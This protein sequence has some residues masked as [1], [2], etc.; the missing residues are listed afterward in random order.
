MGAR[1]FAA[2]GRALHHSEAVLLVNHAK[3]Q[4][5]EIHPFLN[6]GVGADDYVNIT[7]RDAL[8][9]FLLGALL[10]ASYYE[11]NADGVRKHRG[12]FANGLSIAGF[13][14]YSAQQ[15]TNRIEVLL[16]QNLCG[17]HEC[18][19]IA[20]GGS[21]QHRR[22][23]YHC[24]AAADLPLQEPAH[25]LGF[26]QVTLN[27]GKGAHLGRGQFVRQGIEEWL[28]TAA[29]YIEGIPYPLFLPVSFLGQ[30]S[31]LDEEELIESQSLPGLPLA[32]LVIRV[33]SLPN[34]FMKWQQ[35]RTFLHTFREEIWQLRQPAVEC[36][37]D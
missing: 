24:L 1:A 28:K 8:L 11:S 21:E 6:Q 32:E 35:C 4:A 25:R 18:S 23:S 26:A 5:L 20:V 9:D 3:P 31:K 16:C 14:A 36:S 27:L 19:L 29:I 17:R 2:Q 30:H 33:V 34:S 13:T 10:E 15:A 22:R 7:S 37:F 12:K